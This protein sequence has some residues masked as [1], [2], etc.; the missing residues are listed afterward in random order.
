MYYHKKK[1]FIEIEHLG[2]SINNS[3]STKV[4]EITKKIL[5]KNKISFTI[6]RRIFSEIYFRISKEK[7]TEKKRLIFVIYLL[8]S[9]VLNPYSHQTKFKI[10]ILWNMFIINTDKLEKLIKNE[11]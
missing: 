7:Y 4:L 6:K 8:Q 1:T 11:E 3:T 10:N 9:L 2:R 5:R